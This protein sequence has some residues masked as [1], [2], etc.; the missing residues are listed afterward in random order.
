[1]VFIEVY[2]L[3]N[4]VDS[5]IIQR[6][7]S[8]F[9]DRKLK[10]KKNLS[11][12]EV[13]T[14]Q[15]CIDSFSKEKPVVV[16][17][18]SIIHSDKEAAQLTSAN[19]HD[20]EANLADLEEEN[21]EIQEHI[22]CDLNGSGK[23]L[24][25]SETAGEVQQASKKEDFSISV[26]YD[27]IEISI[28]FD[29]AEVPGL[30]KVEVNDYR[31]GS[32]KPQEAI[33]DKKRL[34][35][36]AHN[37]ETL[38]NVVLGLAETAEE[39]SSSVV[40]TVDISEDGNI[41]ENGQ[42]VEDGKIVEYGII[43]EYGNIAGDDNIEDE[44]VEIGYNVD[45][46]V[47]EDIIPIEIDTVEASCVITEVISGETEAVEI[48]EKT[49]E[50]E[51]VKIA[52]NTE[53]QLEDSILSVK[54]DTVE[55]ASCDMTDSIEIDDTTEEGKSMSY[56][57]DKTVVDIAISDV[58]DITAEL[59]E[60]QE[61]AR[62]GAFPSSDDEAIQTLEISL[63]NRSVDS[64]SGDAVACDLNVNVDSTV[65][66]ETSALGEDAA[67]SIAVEPVEP[68]DIVC[69]SALILEENTIQDEVRIEN[70]T[71]HIKTELDTIDSI[72]VDISS[73]EEDEVVAELAEDQECASDDDAFSSSSDED[74]VAAL[75]GTKTETVDTIN[76]LTFN[77]EDPSLSV[78]TV[79]TQMIEVK[80]ID[81]E[82]Y[83]MPTTEE[84]AAIVSD[85]EVTI[86]ENNDVSESKG[87][88]ED[89]DLVDLFDIAD[90]DVVIT[91]ISVNDV[92]VADIT[93]DVVIATDDVVV[94]DISSDCTVADTFEKQE[95]I[96]SINIEIACDEEDSILVVE[97]DTVEQ[98]ITC[99]VNAEITVEADNDSNNSAGIEPKKK[100][101]AVE[102][103]ITTVESGQH[104]D[105]LEE[106]HVNTTIPLTK[107]IFSDDYDSDEVIENLFSVYTQ[108]S[109]VTII[110]TIGSKHD[111]REI[112]KDGEKVESKNSSI[113]V[114]DEE[115]IE[116]ESISVVHAELDFNE[117]FK[118]DESLNE[119]VDEICDHKVDIEALSEQQDSEIQMNV[120]HTGDH[121]EVN[122]V[123]L[124]EKEEEV[125]VPEE[126][127]PGSAWHVQ[128][129]VNN[130]V[131]EEISVQEEVGVVE[132]EPEIIDI[133][134]E[135]ACEQDFDITTIKEIVE[136]TTDE[137][138]GETKTEE[139]SE[140]T[141]PSVDETVSTVE[142][143]TAEELTVNESTMEESTVEDDNEG[144]IEEK[145]EDE[146]VALSITKSDIKSEVPE[147]PEVII[148]SNA[149]GKINI[150]DVQTFTTE[151]VDESM[152]E[153]EFRSDVVEIPEADDISVNEFEPEE[154]ADDNTVELAT[155]MVS[156]EIVEQ[157]TVCDVHAAV[158]E[159]L[160]TDTLDTESEIVSLVCMTAAAVVA[161]ETPGEESSVSVTNG[162]GESE[163]TVVDP[164]ESSLS[165]IEEGGK[166][167]N[168][169]DE[170]ENENEQ[171]ST[172]TCNGK[173]KLTVTLS[174]G[175]LDVN[176]LSIDDLNYI[177]TNLGA[178][179]LSFY[180]EVPLLD[181]VLSTGWVPMTTT[182]SGGSLLKFNIAPFYGNN[183]TIYFK[184]YGNEAPLDNY[185]YGTF[186][187]NLDPFSDTEAALVSYTKQIIGSADDTCEIYV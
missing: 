161:E 97:G 33:K 121:G 1:M 124:E 10:K 26:I 2:A 72:V 7:K 166:I 79:Y 20:N 62:D 160:E 110:E 102:V 139:C 83:E 89:K 40:D 147:P 8:K 45:L 69:D 54:V 71:V 171:I 187:V 174:N 155:V 93:A 172:V 32:G 158:N 86:K 170:N 114:V 116:P 22:K 19:A 129:E 76:V 57:L 120:E 103:D 28:F 148:D 73:D 17:T 165:V 109:D 117:I 25:F 58:E 59:V 169:D 149:D 38:R 21:C 35:C 88:K 135:I 42:I 15:E 162:E 70:T 6:I 181:Y 96:N 67:E 39:Q 41:A 153:V 184:V 131:E 118:L 46:K 123:I 82:E 11:A 146:F 9:S 43:A 101:V 31:P 56:E 111:E 128:I 115:F 90:D 49:D 164:E 68:V 66:Q 52:C 157:E 24:V 64:A 3:C 176:I 27:N 60:E 130:D 51:T 5:H 94:A 113:I 122:T 18:E 173:V 112:E 132:Q 48:P 134:D 53:V 136:M 12:L 152:L 177:N 104:E 179:C 78:Y 100:T 145:G 95:A 77:G 92:I 142:D 185:Y 143:L 87:I 36:N 23:Q 186:T 30:K 13:T 29:D 84:M 144:G 178:P 156:E 141:E 108:M 61:V 133:L 159:I 127:Q 55:E 75:V 50:D 47:E 4:A 105:Q 63:Q 183:G 44:M 99:D 167:T 126:D 74:N 154:E 137:G 175:S 180:I 16:E 125:S 65:I 80:E 163:E 182:T 119:N 106:Q 138:E 14:I 150:C 98:E 140:I 91:D 151:E 107:D 37:S 85:V 168:E 34:V 81:D